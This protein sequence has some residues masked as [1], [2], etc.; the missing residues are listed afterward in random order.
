VNARLFGNTDRAE[1]DRSHIEELKKSL[2]DAGVMAPDDRMKSINDEIS[3]SKDHLAD[4]VAAA[5]KSGVKV[6]GPDD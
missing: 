4:L 3:K 2:S 5:T 1:W 6:I